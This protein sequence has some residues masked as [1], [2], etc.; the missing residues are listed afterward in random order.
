MRHTNT[1]LYSGGYIG[2]LLIF[3]GTAFVIFL[4]VQQYERIGQRTRDTAEEQKVGTQPQDDGKILYPID[5][6]LDAKATLEA[7]DRAML[8]E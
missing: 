1:K 5:R 2:I 7:R 4:A 6:A 3:L 8:Q